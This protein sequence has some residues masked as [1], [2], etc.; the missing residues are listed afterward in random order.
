MI[1]QLTRTLNSY[2]VAPETTPKFLTLEDI[3]VDFPYLPVQTA[4]LGQGD[5][6]YPILFDLNDPRPGPLLICAEKSAGKT[7]LLKVIANSLSRN[8]SRYDV[9]LSILSPKPEEWAGHGGIYPT[10]E[11]SAGDQVVELAAV[12]EQRRWGRELGAAQVMLLDGLEQVKTWDDEPQI[13][14]DWLLREGPAMNVWTIATVSPEASTALGRLMTGFHTRLLGRV[15]APSTARRLAQSDEG[16]QR[17]NSGVGRFSVQISGNW[18]AFQ[19]PLADA[20]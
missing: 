18:L 13:F 16:P 17:T 8:N 15:N 10:W 19:T 11:R 6:G 4:V 9:Q 2:I 20:L 5:D 3:L 12:A 7:N 1:M 14:F